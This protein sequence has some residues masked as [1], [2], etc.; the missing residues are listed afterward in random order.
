MERTRRSHNGTLSH[1]VLVSN[2]NLIHHLKSTLDNQ[3]TG[4]QHN[5][6]QH[7]FHIPNSP[8][9]LPLTPQSKMAQ[10][11]IQPQTQLKAQPTTQPQALS[12]ALPCSQRPLR[13]SSRLATNK[14]PSNAGG[15][16]SMMDGHT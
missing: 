4:I 5:L 2:T 16:G 1:E 10:S 6:K 8:S 3:H 15:R 14:A 11:I 9:T 7:S 13:R 12:Q